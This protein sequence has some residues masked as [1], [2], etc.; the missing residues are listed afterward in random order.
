MRTPAG[1]ECEFYYE[2]FHRGRSMQECRIQKHPKS[3][4]WTPKVCSRC[5]VPG[6]LRANSSPD[7]HLEL[8]IRPAFL[9]I[10]RKPIVTARCTRHNITI[11]DPYVGCPHCSAERPGLEVF[12]A[13][14]EEMDDDD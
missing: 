3:A 12:A 7:L 2:D 1:E 4:L 5:I 6:I 11:E 8:N 13:A 9:G 14:L 10:N